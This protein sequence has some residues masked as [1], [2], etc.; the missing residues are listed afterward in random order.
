[1]LRARML[2]LRPVALLLT[3][4]AALALAVPAHP[5]TLRENATPGAPAREEKPA[6]PGKPGKKE[7]GEAR[8]GAP[9]GVPRDRGGSGATSRGRP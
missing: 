2:S 5:K 8:P 4:G 6:R 3:A 7:K 1:M 9:T